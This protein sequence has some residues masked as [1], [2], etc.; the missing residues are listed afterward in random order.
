VQRS[1]WIGMVVSTGLF[2]IAG[3][4]GFW[5]GVAPEARPYEVA[6]L[7]MPSLDGLR[8]AR[9]E[10]AVPVASMDP[11]VTLR[12]PASPFD[13]EG[14]GS[15]TL[16]RQN[17]PV[18]QILQELF[19]QA[20]RSY[21]ID[22]RVRGRTSVTVHNAPFVGALFTVLRASPMPLACQHRDDG[23]Y[24]VLPENSNQG[25][26]TGKAGAGSVAPVF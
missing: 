15:V 16:E 5:P 4:V 14:G 3:A 6:T 9:D 8:A 20:G 7:A 21:V 25:L 17:V 1:S 10:P 24:V 11:S 22:S 2:F 19:Q 12:S 18:A 13:G 26:G 23:V